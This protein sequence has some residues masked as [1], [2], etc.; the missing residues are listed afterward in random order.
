[1]LVGNIMWRQDLDVVW[2]AWLVV[3]GFCRV[4]QAFIDLSSFLSD[5]PPFAPSYVWRAIW[6]RLL[7]VVGVWILRYLAGVMAEFNVLFNG[8]Q[9][10]PW[11]WFPGGLFFYLSVAGELS[12]CTV[13]ERSLGLRG[14]QKFSGD[15]QFV[16]GDPRGTLVSWCHPEHSVT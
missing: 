11:W 15:I 13:G 12:R 8:S 14:S 3:L 16:G 9:W 6:L 7:V 4:V 1:M 10:V 2:N 5:N